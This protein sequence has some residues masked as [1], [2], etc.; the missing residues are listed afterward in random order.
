MPELQGYYGTRA[1]IDASVIIQTEDGDPLFAIWN[2]TDSIGR[3]ASF[4]SDLSGEI[5]SFSEAFIDDFIGKA[6]IEGMV[7]SVSTI[8]SIIVRI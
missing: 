7:F 5:D 2:P 3:V 1:K 6:F 4:T 8:S